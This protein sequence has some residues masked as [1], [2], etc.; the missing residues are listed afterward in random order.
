[1]DFK[2]VTNILFLDIETV[3]QHADFQQLDERFQRLW[4]KKAKALKA[5]N[6]PEESYP[7]RAAIYAEF[8]RVLVIGVGHFSLQKGELSFRTRSFSH[9][10]EEQ[11]L[12]DILQQEGFEWP[13]LQAIRH[14]DAW[15]HPEPR[16]LGAAISDKG[17]LGQVVCQT[18]ARMREAAQEPAL[19][20]QPPAAP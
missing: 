13:K 10:D 1:M 14:Q 4:K 20:S 8:G 3:S 11:L 2:T 5:D 16:R 18:S 9:P 7:E 6:P 15:D 19:T 17:A 12:V